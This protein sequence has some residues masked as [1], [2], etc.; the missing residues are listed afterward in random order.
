MPVYWF[1][2]LFGG[3]RLCHMR[4]CFGISEQSRHHEPMDNGGSEDT[5]SLELRAENESERWAPRQRLIT[6]SA[7]SR[8]VLITY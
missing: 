6:S 7:A 4:L 3:L 1:R 2:L 5:G 8:R